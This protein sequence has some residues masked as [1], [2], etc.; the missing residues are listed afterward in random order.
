VCEGRADRRGAAAD[1]EDGSESWRPAHRMPIGR[2]P[3]CHRKLVKGATL[4]VY[5]GFAHGMCTTHKDVIN[6]DLLAFLKATRQA[7]A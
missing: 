4:K 7:V 2:R 3:C 5:P 1:V 6:A